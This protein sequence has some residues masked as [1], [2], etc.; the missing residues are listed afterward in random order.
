MAK[1]VKESNRKIANRM[2]NIYMVS[3]QKG[4]DFL[5]FEFHVATRSKYERFFKRKPFNY[6]LT[7]LEVLIND[8]L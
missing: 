8:L 3:L 4:T 1:G 6:K 2:G 5:T 7:E